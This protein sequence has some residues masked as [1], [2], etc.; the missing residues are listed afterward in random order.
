MQ[1]YIVNENGEKVLLGSRRPDGTIR[2]ERRI[3]AGYIPQDEQAV[4]ES[5]GMMA[6]A[7][8][9]RCPGLDSAQASGAAAAAAKSKAAKKNEK[10]K[11]KKA[12]TEAEQPSRYCGM[13]QDWKQRCL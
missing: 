10:R 1:E 5:R 2:K 3:R 9:P 11:A 7:N 13:C 4:Y 6:R 8:I 12:E